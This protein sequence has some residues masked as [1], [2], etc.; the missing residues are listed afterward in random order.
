MI[1][2]SGVGRVRTV[3]E[4][5]GDA[6]WVVA[7]DIFLLFAVKAARMARRNSFILKVREWNNCIVQEV[8]CSKTMLRRGW[9]CACASCIVRIRAARAR[10][11][12]GSVC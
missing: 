11:E 2:I 3:V 6:T 8:D 5:F 10:V 9:G 7:F 12:N 4:G 1:R